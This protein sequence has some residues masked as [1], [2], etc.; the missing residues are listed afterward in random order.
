M[1]RPFFQFEF[2]ATGRYELLV[3]HPAE[4]EISYAQV[5]GI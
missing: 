2:A 3:G 5:E 4:G 1:S